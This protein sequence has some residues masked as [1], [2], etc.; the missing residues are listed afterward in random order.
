M[1]LP[2]EKPPL[3][4][5]VG[6][7][8]RFGGLLA[9]SDVSF[10]VYAGEIV[11]LI[12][13]NGAGKTTLFNVISG[14]NTATSGSV[15]FEGEDVTRLPPEQLARRGIG[16]TFQVVRPFAG[17]SV[18][19]NVL[20]AALMRHPRRKDAE[21][22]AW[23]ALTVTGLA[24][25]AHKLSSGLTLAGRKRLEVTKALALEPRLLLLDEV[26]AGLNPTEAEKMVEVI[27]SVRATGVTILMVE[28]ILRVIM[29]VSDRLVVLS[30]GE[31]L[32]QGSPAEVAANPA[33][34]E[35]YLGE[36]H[37]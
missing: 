24:S 14:Y 30:S 4:K 34:I 23:S 18:L 6:A 16:R 3:L 29:N 31:L 12:G 15:Y 10:N 1:T 32:A 35:A 8:R 22:A 28:H 33:V 19:E 7:S 13:P 17:L 2:H 36:A 9:V 11:G 27:R 37:S 25:Q 20:V 5:V 21:A 26:V